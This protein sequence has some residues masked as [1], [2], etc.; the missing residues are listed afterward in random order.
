MTQQS[1]DDPLSGYTPDWRKR[2]GKQ[3]PQRATVGSSTGDPL[4]GYTPDWRGQHT[5]DE[6]QATADS[7]NA[8]ADAAV[9]TSGAPP[10][11]PPPRHVN[12]M[13][14]PVVGRGVSYASPEEERA[15]TERMHGY[16]EGVKNVVLGPVK[17]ARDVLRGVAN[18]TPEELRRPDVREYLKSQGQDPDVMLHEAIK[19]RATG[20]SSGP[21]ETARTVGE[22]A[23]RMG[24]ELESA[25]L[26]GPNLGNLIYDVATGKHSADELINENPHM[27]AEAL[28]PGAQLQAITELAANAALFGSGVE[29]ELRGVA[30]TDRLRTAAGS[31][32]DAARKA[33]AT[34]R[35]LVTPKP[36]AAAAAAEPA[37]ASAGQAEPAAPPA[38]L[39]NMSD[40][41]IGTGPESITPERLAAEQTIGRHYSPEE[42]RDIGNEAAMLSA[43]FDPSN[44]R[45][46]LPPLTEVQRARLRELARILKTE[47]ER[48]LV[49]NPPPPL[50]QSAARSEPTPEPGPVPI[51]QPISQQEMLDRRLQPSVRPDFIYRVPTQTI[52]ADPARFQFKETGPGG[53]TPELKNVGTW[54]PQLAGVV[55]VWRDPVDGLT[56]VVNGHHRL[57][58]AQRLGVPE[59]NVQFVDA[60]DAAEARASGAFINMAEGRGTA[61]DVAKFLRDRHAT[62][63]DLETRGVSLRGDITR[64]GLA[65]SKLAPD[66]FDQVATGKAPQQ[67]GVAIGNLLED[68]ALQREA[69]AAARSSGK[70]LSQAEVGEIARQ[71]RDAGTEAVQ[72]ETLF[73]KQEDRHALYANRAQLAAAL[74]RQ[75][76]T[77]RRLFG[78]VSREGRAEQLGRAGSTQIDVGAARTLAEQASQA[79][80]IFDRLY[81]RSG[82][83]AEA[84]HAGAK[85]IAQ[86]E[87]P[88]AVAADIYPAIS[89]AVGA[90]LAGARVAGP[91]RGEHAP[92]AG[93]GPAAP[94]E[95]P[96]V[97]E[98]PPPEEVAAEPGRA[99]DSQDPSQG[100]FFTTEA[101]AAGS[102]GSS[103]APGVR[104][105]ERGSVSAE[106]A[107]LLRAG[108]AKHGEPLETSARRV[109]EQ[110]HVDDVTARRLGFS[111]ED[112]AGL[113]DL[114]GDL[115][116]TH[117]EG[118]WRQA[119]TTERARV[120]VEGEAGGEIP[121]HIIIGAEDPVN[122][123]GRAGM[124]LVEHRMDGQLVQRWYPAT[125]L[126]PAAEIGSA[127]R[128]A[129]DLTP[130][131]E[132]PGGQEAM[133]GERAGTPASR[134]LAQSEAAARSELPRLREELRLT[135]DAHQRM[136]LNAKIAELEKLVNRGR[137]LTADEIK[138]QAAARGEEPVQVGPEQRD[139]FT[140]SAGGGRPRPVRPQAGA[141]TPGPVT[142]PASR[143]A[144]SGLARAA[145]SVRRL[146]APAGRTAEAGLTALN[147]R[148]NA[149]RLA[150]R[151]EQARAALATFAKMWD[152]APRAVRSLR[153]DF[154]KA[155]DPAARQQLVGRLYAQDEALQFVDRMEKGTAQ[156]TPELTRAAK[157][158]R[159]LMDGRRDAIRALGTGKLEHFIEDYFPHI[160]ENPDQAQ[161]VLARIMGKR[162][163]EGPR[164]FLKQRSIPTIRE[165]LEAGL[166]PVT[167]NPADLVLLKLREMDRYRM[168]QEIMAEEKSTGRARF[169]S[170]FEKAEPGNI[171]INDHVA[172]VYGP[173]TVPVKE[174][175]DLLV[176]QKLEQVIRDLGGLKHERGPTLHGQHGLGY[177]VG[178]KGDFMAT[179]S[180]TPDS[181]IMHELGHIVDFRYHLWDRLTD[182]PGKTKEA[183]RARK[184][185]H[186]EL[187]DLAD[188]RY[189]G[190]QATDTFKSYVRNKYEKMANAI[191]ALIY[192][193]D[194]MRSVA[195]TIMGRLTEFLR[196]RP[197]L[198]PLLDIKPSLV[199]GVAEYEQPVGGMVIVG[200]YY[201]PEPVATVLNN[202]LSP[203]LSGNA[204]FDAYRGIGNVLNQVQLGLS[205][206]HLGFTSMD[207]AVSKAALGVEQIVA[208]RPLQGAGSIAR[209]PVAPVENLIRGHKLL[210]EVLHPGTGG[211]ELAAIAEAL[212]AGGGRVRMD[213]FY[214]NS[215]VSKF[216]DALQ[217]G[218]YA[219]AGLRTVPAL[220]E[221]AAKPLMEWIVPRQKLGVFA[222][223]A[224]FELSRLPKEATQVEIRAAMAKVWDSVD[225]RMG[226]LVYDNLFWNKALKDLGMASV[227]SLGWNIGTLREIG[228]GLVDVAATPARALRGDRVLTHRMAYVI[229][230]PFAVGVT[231]GMLHYLLTG[232]PP[233]DLKDYFFPRTGRQT[234]EGQPERV[235]LPSYMRDVFHV[236]R[237][238]LGTISGK[239]HPLITYLAD[240][241]QNED[242]FGNKIRNEQDPLVTELKQVLDYTADQFVPI[243]IRQA[244]Q[245][246]QRGQG[247]S[248]GLPFFGVTPAPREEVR[249]EAE[250]LTHELLGG[251]ASGALTPEEATA[252]KE[253]RQM[254]D[255]L[256]QNDP[257]AMADIRDA[258]K[259]GRLRPQQATRMIK[260]R[261]LSSLVRGF[262]MLTL[263]EAVR[264]FRSADP[265]E[266]RALFPYLN[267][268]AERA[269]QFG[270]REGLDAAKTLMRELR[271]Q[272]RAVP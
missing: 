242:Y 268:K 47:G 131:P 12:A 45:T 249:S 224:R 237:H 164:S 137:S 155:T 218:R 239:L 105:T 18:Y 201:A 260:E 89:D 204:L 24:H 152:G 107:D 230:L 91:D 73:G 162:P 54:N 259:A 179:R 35:R 135:R 142:A 173:P 229:A 255:A 149:A 153:E 188:L 160:W 71:V 233:K 192:A 245:E 270:D 151:G 170:A 253:R 178:P 236:R 62:P 19:R 80:E 238:P 228:G 262:R 51:A 39:A 29:S 248:A 183:I 205:A 22:G 190:Q 144:P 117:E 70:R 98:G 67:W 235:Q 138:A 16:A 182:L 256:R 106:E 13:P 208:G 119:V 81:T 84:V 157:V 186:Q 171:Q 254:A 50:E 95:A 234:P 148:E 174:A 244:T 126:R 111:K 59:I 143:A 189:E 187:R 264:V 94:H 58:L 232:E 56:Y 257:N 159:D 76:S 202:F 231:G 37:I 206:F 93:E 127:A 9:A 161:T 163:L 195:P 146:F 57:E 48:Q 211:P 220:L 49:E 99:P 200:H 217:R 227:R 28:K 221:L 194:K 193:P 197:E 113:N 30:L 31:I 44:P 92:V 116:L 46:P 203:G 77:D 130:E 90:E 240:M 33:T 43:R 36:A 120:V 74:K 136:V 79:E 8:A 17:F 128:P 20:E 241:W 216:W 129:L 180:G 52:A 258:L 168:G 266:R 114:M 5:A 261:R 60:P 66:V 181:V 64:D 108:I 122:G 26:P 68:P 102:G 271:G 210:K 118:A 134:N 150:V 34:G 196:E 263:T 14:P 267:M 15:A 63:A 158:L 38:P 27:I 141:Q 199:H 86:G 40:L 85:R 243:G 219:R 154:A 207:A 55:S 250:N 214:R 7:V 198:K 252:V 21:L 147:V 225:N 1:Q 175:F 123:V 88:S 42:L 112:A 166:V 69:L 23:V 6:S 213:G 78:Y 72:Q 223:L 191:M 156:P 246:K 121:G 132:G 169:V 222:D 75:L 2:L 4:A 251:R 124:A 172:T 140:V 103:R 61:T 265:D 212:V 53:V 215:A 167:W 25:A 176:R 87:R 110:G 11:E 272:R 10:T 177:A 165:G 83:I 82:P 65:L 269:A 145:D 139:M 209:F 226:Q 115:R 100:G 96:P 41:N 125:R 185:L 104:Q 133:F 184:A 32:A 247:R 101:R 3:A 97:V 109:A